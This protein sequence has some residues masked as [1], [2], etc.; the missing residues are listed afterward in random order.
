[1]YTYSKDDFR[2]RKFSKSRTSAFGDAKLFLDILYISS[3]KYSSKND[4]RPQYRSK[5]IET[6]I[7]GKHFRFVRI[8]T[9]Q[10]LIV[11][12]PEKQGRRMREFT[13]S[14]TIFGEFFKILLQIQRRTCLKNEEESFPPFK[15]RNPFHLH[16][17][18]HSSAWHTFFCFSF[19]LLSRARRR[20]IRIFTKFI[21]RA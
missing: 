4:Y 9:R 2:N 18:D 19:L 14:L 17:L 10:N 15:R 1:M 5:D 20:R 7:K 6:K 13:T 21:R 3:E 16:N 11:V 8:F 12:P